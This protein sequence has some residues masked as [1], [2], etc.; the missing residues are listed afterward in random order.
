MNIL[1]ILLPEINNSQTHLP[2]FSELEF[3]F[4]APA[5]H[6]TAWRIVMV[7]LNNLVL[8]QRC[9]TLRPVPT[10][11]RVRTERRNRRQATLR[12][13]TKKS[14]WLGSTSFFW[15]RSSKTV[16]VFFVLQQNCVRSIFFVV[17]NKVQWLVHLSNL[18]L[19]LIQFMWDIVIVECLWQVTTSTKA[20]SCV[21]TPWYRILYIVILLIVQSVFGHIS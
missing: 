1:K 18:K 8:R 5:V 13:D 9:L 4:I 10:S 20:T 14:T 12:E 2:N 3:W 21:L 6:R 17:F 19:L 7:R 16:D 11:A 15:R